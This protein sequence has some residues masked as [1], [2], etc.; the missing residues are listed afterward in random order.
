MTRSTRHGDL[1]TMRVDLTERQS[2]SHDLRAMT[3]DNDHPDESRMLEP[4]EVTLSV[5]GVQP[6]KLP[7]GEVRIMV[8]NH[9]VRIVGALTGREGVTEVTPEHIAGCETDEAFR[10]SIL[11]Y[12]TGEASC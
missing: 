12:V 6:G 7:V 8:D 10:L 1:T 5:A 9:E 2:W 4:G 3:G 11:G